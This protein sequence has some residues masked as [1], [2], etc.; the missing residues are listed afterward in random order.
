[1]VDTVTVVETAAATGIPADEDPVGPEFMP[2]RA[3]G[4]RVLGPEHGADGSDGVGHRRGPGT[5]R[6]GTGPSSASRPRG[7]V[8]GGQ[9]IRK[10][11]PGESRAVASATIASNEYATAGRKNGV[12]AGW[13]HEGRMG[14]MLPADPAS[15]GMCPPERSPTRRPSRVTGPPE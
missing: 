3:V 11:L 12:C 14:P 5:D 1:D 6:V 9:A 2:V 7:G 8:P 4:G 13:I 15:G 10:P